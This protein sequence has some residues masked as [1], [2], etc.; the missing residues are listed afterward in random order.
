MAVSAPGATPSDVA[1]LELQVVD[2]R[3]A[4]PLQAAETVLRLR[5]VGGVLV[6]TCSQD[7]DLGSV[8]YR[9]EYVFLK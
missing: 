4:G 5:T 6:G 7:G 2:H 1:L 9:A 8:P 3:G